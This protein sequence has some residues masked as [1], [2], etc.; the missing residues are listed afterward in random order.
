MD[1]ARITLY[2]KN[3]SDAVLRDINVSVEGG[4]ENLQVKAPKI[5]GPNQIAEVTFTW[6]PTLFTKPL[7]AHIEVTANEVAS[8]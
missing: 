1:K 4:D 2:L 5:L 6:E 8:G 3:D 7:D